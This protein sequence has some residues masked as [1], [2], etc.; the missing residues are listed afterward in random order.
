M[1]RKIA[2]L[3]E[4]PVRRLQTPAAAAPADPA[5]AGIEAVPGAGRLPAPLTRFFGRGAEMTRLCALLLAEE[6]RLVTLTGPGGSG[7]TR[8]ALELAR[9]L[10][11]AWEG[12][13]YSVSLADLADPRLIAETLCDALHLPRAPGVEPLDQAA[14][15]LSRRPALLLLDNFEHLI[16][17]GALL[18][19][20][21]LERVPVLTCLMTSRQRLDLEG[22]RVFPVEPLPVPIDPDGSGALPLLHCASV[23][24][25]VDRAQGVN[26]GFCL[27]ETNA[28]AVAALCRRLEGIPLA[29]ELAAART[30]ALSPAQ[31]LDR[32]SN[33]YEFLVRRQR[34]A[35]ARHRSLHAAIDWS[36]RLLPCELQRFFAQLWVFRGG[37]SLTAAEQVCDEP[38]ALEYLEQ[39][40]DCSMVTVQDQGGEA[41]YRLLETLREYGQ[42]QL[43]AAEGAS[44]RDRHA[45]YYLAFAEEAEP[46]LWGAGQAEWLARLEGEY[47]NLRAALEWS[48]GSGDAET[49]LRLSTAVG[50]FWRV[51]GYFRE[52]QGWLEAALR[53]SEGLGHTELRAKALCRAGRLVYLQGDCAAARTL[54]EASLDMARKLGDAPTTA[55]ALH[56]LALARH[57]QGD[58]EAAR[59]LAE[60]SL[61]LGRQLGDRRITAIALTMLG[62]FAGSKGDHERARL[63]TGEGVGILREI[64]DKL[65]LI[66]P[67]TGLGRLVLREGDYA[68]ARAF[69]EETLAL[70]REIG[71]SLG[72][73]VS[74]LHLGEVA[75]LQGDYEAACSL[76]RQGLAVLRQGEGPAVLR[77]RGCTGLTAR[78]L[79]G[80]A[81]LAAAKGELHRAAR[82]LAATASLRDANGAPLEPEEAARISAEL[83]L[84]R[85]ELGEGVFDAA[86]AAGGAMSLDQAVAYA[87]ECQPADD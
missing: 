11:P 46:R 17:E 33:R 6:R 64:G 75:R 81:S 52:G 26:P 20:T 73:G 28:A 42:E 4:A 48:L 84:A 65:S 8:L 1:A 60:E 34:D 32:L 66:A 3:A 80:F 76:Y 40:R 12:H 10:V 30:G 85:K 86:S 47:D 62:A 63:L 23:Q 19:R 2:A 44:L 59:A 31:M 15:A 77:Q 87:L 16:A 14:A 5:A 27:N 13:V 78:C 24:L 71:E 53:H 38:Q 18:V 57:G 55:L 43:T 45:R 54:Y 21:L 79:E 56:G 69:F 72:I 35:P 61:A 7:K 41:R 29:I 82:L 36:F 67:L 9:R 83:A 58:D 74:Y 37:W 39:L 25:F 50:Q 51:R 22:E 70:R 68:A 49:A